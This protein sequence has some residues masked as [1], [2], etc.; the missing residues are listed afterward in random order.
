MI[1]K[2]L[3]CKKEITENNCKICKTC[4]EFLEW[5]Y[6]NKPNDLKRIK[7]FY[8]KSA[9]ST[10]LNKSRRKKWEKMS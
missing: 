2:C 7:E 3:V 6:E 10:Q 4:L 8:E 9:N 5:K 1:K